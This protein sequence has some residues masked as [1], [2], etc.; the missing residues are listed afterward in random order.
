MGSERNFAVLAAVVMI[1]LLQSVASVA[2]TGP[3]VPTWPQDFSI[4]PG[5]KADFGVP[6]TQPGEIAVKVE[7]KGV[8]LTIIL[9]DPSGAS[10]KRLDLQP[11][12]SASLLHSATA[13]DVQK[14][15]MWTVSIAA[16]SARPGL[17]V[18]GEV[19]PTAVGQISIQ[20]P[21]ADMSRVSVQIQ[22]LEARATTRLRTAESIFA[23]RALA[24]FNARVAEFD[25]SRLD[26]I[27]TLQTDL[28]TRMN[29]NIEQINKLILQTSVAAATAPVQTTG[30]A[31]APT[32][33]QLPAP[34][35][36]EPITV[37]V[38]PPPTGPAPD[39]TLLLVTPNAGVPGDMVTIKTT[40]MLADKFLSEAWFM[41]NPGVTVQAKVLT[42]TKVASGVNFEAQVPN[43]AGVTQGYNGQ[44]FMKA[45][46]HSPVFITNS[47]PFRFDPVPKPEIASFD[48][49][50]AEPGIWLTVRGLNFKPDNQVHF[51]LDGGR[52]V[53]A[54][55]RYNSGTEILA[56]VPAYSANQAT[57]GLL[58]M[59]GKFATGWAKSNAVTVYL[60]A[61]Y[62]SISSLDRAE[63]APGEPL[64]ISGSGFKPPVQVRFIIN[65]GR[66]EAGNV[67]QMSTDTQILAYV[68]N[69]GGIATPF[70]GYV[71]VVCANGRTDMK[72]FR[73]R[74]AMELQQM[75]IMLGNDYVNGE[76]GYNPM[77]RG[78][79]IRQGHYTGPI[80][81][82]K[83]DDI[84]F[85]S[86]TLKNGWVVD[87]IQ[88]YNE[89]YANSGEAHSFIAAN[90]VGTSSPYTKVHWWATAGGDWTIYELRYTIKGPRGISPY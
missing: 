25:K 88:F 10:V 73:F 39:P 15:L 13:A 66:D 46:D 26:T 40:G 43:A 44:V 41:I 9:K 37:T 64:L 79:Y 87:S 14:G 19:E 28:R 29:L 16:P 67:D 1:T 76:A 24:D 30:Q 63:G 86:F 12:P 77:D 20:S 51:V 22:T 11:P 57:Q 53:S 56:K 42:V 75:R 81:G 65:P 89:D 68:P 80:I 85:L 49:A 61:T 71:Y 3:A 5:E 84:Y 55:M 82:H 36:P 34:K 2:G 48:P 31:P 90:K 4:G 23:Q 18:V 83:G 54:E 62:P 60:K 7:W 58:Y 70:D 21:K 32:I 52:D 38:P 69:A 6:V 27:N 35:A 74:P 59:M 78:T 72:P 45:K 50:A 17:R 47:L 33:S 8:P